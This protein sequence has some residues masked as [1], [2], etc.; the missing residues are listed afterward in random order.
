MKKFICV[1]LSILLLCPLMIGCTK[2]KKDS[3]S[4]TLWMYNDEMHGNQ[5]ELYDDVIKNFRLHNS[6]VNF[7]KVDMSENTSEN[8]DK[9]LQTLLMAGKGP[10][11]IFID[12]NTFPDIYK[13]MKS[14][15]FCDINKFLNEDKDYNA[16]NYYQD[17]LKAA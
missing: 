12:R 15:A 14:G 10:D 6:G 4:I 16:D 1:I 7:Y 17:V 11:I 5:Y 9:K 8:S 3:K 13:T 2:L